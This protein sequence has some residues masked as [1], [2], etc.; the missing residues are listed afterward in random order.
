MNTTGVPMNIDFENDG[1]DKLMAEINMTPLIDIMLVLLII[2][3]VTSSITLESGL[4]IELP[5]TSTKTE[6]K[7]SNVVI[8]SVDA[9]SNISIQGKKI[10]N[11]ELQS[12]I[13]KALAQEKTD[14]VIFE[15]DTTSTIGR[16]I[17]IMDLAKA[18]GAQKFAV[19]TEGTEQATKK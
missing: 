4:D 10:S 18:A 6:K 16:M 9:K 15:G 12:E 2:F 17:E 13:A 14:E 3:M 19:A 5:K 7:E 11:G 1:Q 8:V